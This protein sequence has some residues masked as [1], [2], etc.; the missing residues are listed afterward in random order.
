MRD[1]D[2]VSS[3]PETPCVCGHMPAA[4]QY[5]DGTFK[6]D[7]DEC[8]CKSYRPAADPPEKHTIYAW[9]GEDE[10]GS[11]KVGIKH[12]IVP[13]G[14]VPLVAM[15]YDLH[16]IARMKPMLEVQAKLYG[17]KIRLVK[18]EA[19]EIAAETEAGS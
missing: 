4:H 2:I 7:C 5:S 19:V 1:T 14:D 11:G 9:I 13:A 18:F 8:T 3:R 12:A 15:S 16:K 10:L 17:K 6:P